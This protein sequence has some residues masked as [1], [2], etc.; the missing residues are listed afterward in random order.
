MTKWFRWYR[1]IY[2]NLKDFTA[3]SSKFPYN[4]LNSPNFTPVRL[5]LKL[6]D[7]LEAQLL[8]ALR[9]VVANIE[10]GYARPTTGEYLEFLGFSQ[11][12]LKEG[13]GDIHRMRQDGLIIGRPG[14]SLADSIIDL[15]AWHSALKKSVVSRPDRSFPQSVSIRNSYNFLQ[16]P[17]NSSKFNYPPVD[18]FDPAFLTFEI[19]IELVNKTDWQLRRLVESLEHKLSVDKKDYQIDRARIGFNLRWRP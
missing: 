6:L 12:S 7:R 19:L 9:S 15:S 18:N 2:R 16:Y 13:K 4:P 3:E 10:E 14:S 1:G 17:I 11:A 8:D 5:N